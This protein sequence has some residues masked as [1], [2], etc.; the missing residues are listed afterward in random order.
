MRPNNYYIKML[1]KSS[2]PKHQYLSFTNEFEIDD[3]FISLSIF[4]KYTPSPIR[5]GNSF[6]TIKENLKL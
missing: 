2:L 6:S 5:K 1:R 4:Y 3:N